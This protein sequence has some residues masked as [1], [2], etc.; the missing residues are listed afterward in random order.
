MDLGD[1]AQVPLGAFGEQCFA[2]QVPL[3]L[4]VSLRKEVVDR[5]LDEEASRVS[6]ERPPRASDRQAGQGCLVFHPKS[7][8]AAKISAMV[9]KNEVQKEATEK[10]VET[11]L[12]YGAGTFARRHHLVDIGSST[13]H[14][15]QFCQGQNN[16]LQEGALHPPRR[17]THAR[18]PMGQASGRAGQTG[19]GQADEA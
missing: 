9:N 1:F 12:D 13:G 19:L 6:E 2:D 3:A 5:P 8:K 10:E 16:L 7:A 18:R 14:R 17:D 11:I 4:R 15:P